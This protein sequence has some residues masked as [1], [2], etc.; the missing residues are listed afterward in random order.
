MSEFKRKN[1]LH[2]GFNTLVAEIERLSGQKIDFNAVDEKID[3]NQIRRHEAIEASREIS[4]RRIAN[5]QNYI[6]SVYAS[7]RINPDFCFAKI[8]RDPANTQAII[9]AEGFCASYNV[10]MN[11][12]SAPPMLL[13]QGEPGSGKT[14][15][16]NCIANR[17]LTEMWKDVE[18]VN[19][20]EVKRTRAPNLNDTY[21]DMEEKNSRWQR[22]ISVDLLII[23]ALCQNKEALTPFDRQVISELLRQ[24][25]SRDLPLVITTPLSPMSMHSHLGDE[26][27]ESMKEYSVMTAALFGQSRR[28]PISFGGAPL[29]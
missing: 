1:T 29:L 27:F 2:N 23:D 15:I 21:S 8:M 24:R 14:V 10:A 6:N 26:I 17:F 22:F 25:R 11:S 18:L 19:Y 7:H 9:N 5:H 16:A 3:I 13:L 20:Q 28:T 4:Q 12:D